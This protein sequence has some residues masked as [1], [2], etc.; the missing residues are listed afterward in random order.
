MIDFFNNMKTNKGGKVSFSCVKR[1]I[2]N[3]VVTNLTKTLVAI[4]RHM[5]PKHLLTNSTNSQ[6][7]V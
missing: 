5:G 7:M 6:A 3:E 4:M 1:T 2:S